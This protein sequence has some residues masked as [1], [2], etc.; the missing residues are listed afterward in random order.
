MCGRIYV[1]SSVA[2]LLENF[3]WAK[4]KAGHDL[5][6]LVPK[7]NGAP[8]HTYP[9]IA[10]EADYPGG[11]F[12]S[13]RWGLVPAWNKDP[14]PKIMPINATAERVSDA[15]MFR[16]AYRSRRALLPIDGFFEWRAAKGKAPKQPYAIA[17]ADGTP[18]CVAVI[19][20]TWK[21]PGSGEE[22]K[23][24][25]IVTCPAN[26]LVSHIHNRMPVIIAPENYQCWIGTAEDDPRDLLNPYPS[27]LMRT[28]P[29]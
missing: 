19:W 17:M 5:D 21:H 13:A 1:K 2:E 8:A 7:Y 18:F 15:P 26:D 20:E 23:T 12:V 29:V 22:I 3:A 24:F 27:E 6:G 9:I 25:A 28:W 16:A 4:R 14:R 10:Q 11:M